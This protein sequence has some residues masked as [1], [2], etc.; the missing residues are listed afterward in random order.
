MMNIYREMIPELGGYLT[1]KDK[2]HLP[3][4][5]LFMQEIARREPLYFQQRAIDE[6]EEAYAGEKYREHYYKVGP[7]ERR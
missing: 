4:I 5:E 6:K 3:R 7:L 1:D 2:V